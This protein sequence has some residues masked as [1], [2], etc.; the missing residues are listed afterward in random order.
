M[1]KPKDENPRLIFPNGITTTQAR[2]LADIGDALAPVG[3]VALVDANLYDLDPP[4]CS[5]CDR[6]L[7]AGHCYACK[8]VFGYG[9]AFR[10]GRCR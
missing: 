1:A 6:V 3:A 5:C 2:R 7:E 4:R 9:D 8:P 10:C